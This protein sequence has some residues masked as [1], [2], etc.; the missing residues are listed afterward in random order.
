MIRVAIVGEIGC[1]KSYIS[2]KFGAPV[3]NADVEVNRLYKKSKKCYKKLRKALP[4]Y[5]TSW[6]IKKTNLA[7]AIESNQKNIKKITK[8]IHPEI[9]L[10]M[11]DFIKKNKNKKFV[12][13][14]IPLFLENKINKKNDV[15]IFVDAKKK[16][17]YKRLKKRPNINFKIVKKLKK[18]QLPIE[19]KKK[20]S[21]FIIKNN[22]NNKY[23]K[24]DVTKVKKKILANA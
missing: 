21:N 12:V 7:K 9:R 10:K 3:F 20:K 6:P 5:I 23:I 4:K 16:D 17:I 11:N 22:F 1:G 8:I 13:L 24:K 19:I 15:I 14:D 2:K 18:L